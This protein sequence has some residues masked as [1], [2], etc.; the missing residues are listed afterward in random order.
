VSLNGAET[1]HEALG[2]AKNKA[3]NRSTLG[4]TANEDRNCLLHTLFQQP[5]SSKLMP[6]T[7]WRST[8]GKAQNP[9]RKENE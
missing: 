9:R 8:A 1:P 2:S 5:A 7:V 6:R 3:K 4:N